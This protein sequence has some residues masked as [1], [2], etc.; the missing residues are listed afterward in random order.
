VKLGFWTLGM[1]SWTTA[2]TADRARR[3]GYRG[4]ALRCSRPEN[5][6]PAGGADVCVETPADQVEATVKSFAEADVEIVSVVYDGPN[7]HAAP[8]L[9]WAPLAAD[10][11]AHL[12]L[13]ARLGAPRIL[14]PVGRPAMRVSWDSHLNAL[15]DM[16]SE[17][18]ETVPGVYAMFE[19]HT[20]VAT[21]EQLLRMCA[22]RGN[23]R[24]GVELSPDHCLVM[25]EDTIRLID[26]YGEFIH[27]VCWA[28]RRA[29]PDKLGQFDG[30]YYYVRYETC[31]NGEGL[32]PTQKIIDALRRNGFAGYVCLKWEKSASFGRQLPTGDVALD[33]FKS[34]M[35]GFGL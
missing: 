23:P 31:V 33:Q 5:G 16:V 6:R 10:L 14:V 3:S 20:G 13:V 21:G 11:S 8:T 12:R 24:I 30:R 35:G 18:L 1:P 19:N 4:V 25:Q 27:Q 34:F 15:W 9:E 26:E 2:E 22:R 32:V 7:G 28:D 29:V 17:A